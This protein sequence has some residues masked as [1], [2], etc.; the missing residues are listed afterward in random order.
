[1]EV[2]D[3]R[4]TCAPFVD[5]LLLSVMCHVACRMK[6]IPSQLAASTAQHSVPF[7]PLPLCTHCFTL[8]WA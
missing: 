6:G 2:T 5:V 3:W 7:A 4:K 8:G 1:M